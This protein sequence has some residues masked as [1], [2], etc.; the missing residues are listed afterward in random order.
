MERA[1]KI[2][3]EE[4]YRTVTVREGEKIVEMPAIRAV[5]RS[6]LRDALKGNGPNQ[7][8]VLG[9]IQAL[10]SAQAQAIAAINKPTGK[11]MTD[12][13]GARRIAFALIRASRVLNQKVDS[14][15]PG[16]TSR[17]CGPRHN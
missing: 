16:R 13:E 12:L 8:A 2:V 9:L 17:E 4:A 11:P 3:L 5:M 15:A 14:R 7:R 6:H 1:R 10:E